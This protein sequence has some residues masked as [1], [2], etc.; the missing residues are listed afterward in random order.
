MMRKEE[1]KKQPEQETEEQKAKADDTLPQEKKEYD[2]I[3]K[4]NALSDKLGL[5][6]EHRTLLGIKETKD[7]NIKELYLKEGDWN[8]DEPWFAIEDNNDK[9]AYA[10]IPAD[11]FAHLI[12]TLQHAQQENFNLKLE[13][14]IWQNIP[15]DFE[16]VWVVAMDE[17]RKYAQQNDPNKAVSIDLD[18]L[19]KKIKKEHPNLFINLRDFLPHQM[20]QLQDNHD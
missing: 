15:S 13:K 9:K 14:T 20:N 5:S 2:I 18:K 17:I 12:E 1:Q 7:P 3:E 8:E 11:A 10:F 4:I 16:D 19:I 6:R